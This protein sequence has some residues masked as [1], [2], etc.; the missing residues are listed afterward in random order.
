MLEL[1]ILGVEAWDEENEVF[2]NSEDQTLHLEHSLV[3]L[4][5][6]ESRWCKPFLTNDQKTREETVDYIRCM[7]LDKD[8][9]P[10]AYELI[11]QDH[12]DQ[13]YTYINAAMTA[14][15]FSSFDNRPKKPN[16]TVVTSELIYYWMVALQIP[17]ECETWHLNRLLTLIR[18]TEVK[19]S[20]VKKMNKRDLASRYAEINAANRRKFNSKG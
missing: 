4:S 14:T 9:D 19:N 15:T 17:F 18:V 7:T 1:N 3:S 11:T 5:K 13:V 2:I 20:P 6:W 12:I 16:N 10:T 8:V